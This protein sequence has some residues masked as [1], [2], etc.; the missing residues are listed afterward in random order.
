MRS[1]RAPGFTL[2]ELLVVIAIIAILAAMLLPALSNAKE[3]A[4]RIACLN[5]LKQMGA[6]VFMYAGDHADRV[7][8][9][10]YRP[11]TQPY[12]AYLLCA[13]IGA[14]GVNVNMNTSQPTNHGM[15][16]VTGLM[17]SGK[18]Y[19]CP[20]VS[21]DMDQRFTFDNYVSNSGGHWPVYSKLAGSTAFL[22]SSYMYYPQTDELVT[23]GNTNSGYRV[24]LKLGQLNVKRVLMTDLIYAYDSI[25][26]RAGKSPAALNVL[27]GDAHASICTTRAAFTP[28]RWNPI[29]GDN[30]ST[31]RPIISM[32]QP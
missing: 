21:P 5:N 8:S 4:K 22:R 25:P 15:L 2:I 16:Y 29:P 17:R 23:A 11:G 9:A 3:R 26:H 14:N 1:R 32:L 31:F 6:A 28:A 10:Q 24:A 30:D 27:W 20:S 13:N 19:Y 18:N 7:P 12:Q